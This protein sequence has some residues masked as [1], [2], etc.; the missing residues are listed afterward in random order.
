MPLLVYDC[1]FT[2][3]I[4]CKLLLIKYLPNQKFFSGP[5]Y[6]RMTASAQKTIFTRFSYWNIH[7]HVQHGRTKVVCSPAFQKAINTGLSSNHTNT[8]MIP[9]VPQTSHE[10]T[11]VRAALIRKLV[12]REASGAQRWTKLSEHHRV[13]HCFRVHIIS[14]KYLLFCFS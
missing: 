3:V 6:S 13:L 4:I 10:A 9:T 7:S 8:R 14:H 11:T 1:H 5:F 2:K 12:L